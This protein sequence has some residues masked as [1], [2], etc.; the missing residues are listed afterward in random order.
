MNTEVCPPVRPGQVGICVQ[1]CSNDTQCHDNKKCCFNGCGQT[2]QTPGE[3]IEFYLLS[4]YIYISVCL[5]IG[6]HMLL[7]DA[8]K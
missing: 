6:C 3:V 4:I 2:C 5:L 7:S 1:E 8:L